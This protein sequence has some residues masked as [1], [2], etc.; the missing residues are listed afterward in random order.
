MKDEFE[1]TV[2]VEA[3]FV[4]IPVIWLQYVT[5]SAKTKI[6]H[7]KTMSQSMADFCS[8]PL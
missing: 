4:S 5:A 1:K 8:N 2:V 7:G 3:I 6:Q